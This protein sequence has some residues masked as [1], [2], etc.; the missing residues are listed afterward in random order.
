VPLGRDADGG[1]P[2]LGPSPEPIT[3]GRASAR[4]LNFSLGE[5]ESEMKEIAEWFAEHPPGDVR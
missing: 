4:S 1:C 2:F 5:F 3:V